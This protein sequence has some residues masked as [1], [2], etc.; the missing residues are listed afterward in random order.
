MWSASSPALNIPPN[1]S[2]CARAVLPV[3]LPA[4]HAGSDRVRQ[5]QL[6]GEV[7]AAH[8]GRGGLLGALPRR[9]HLE[10]LLPRQPALRRPVSD[11]PHLL[12]R[13]KFFLGRMLICFW[14]SE[15]VS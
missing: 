4:G 5:D 15:C 12:V 6:V 13:F 10:V 1:L 7:P 14:Q 11:T 9:F 2:L 3:L 8:A